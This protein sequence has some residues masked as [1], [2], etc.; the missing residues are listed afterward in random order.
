MRRQGSPQRPPSQSGPGSASATG[1]SLDALFDPRSI[2]VVGASDDPAK[3]GHILSRRALENSGDR[4]VVLVNRRGVPVL[5][6]ASH[7]TVAAAT[8]ATG[9]PLDRVVVCVPSREL[10]P[11]VAAALEAGARSLVVITAGLSELGAEGAATEDEVVRLV[12][13]AGAV[14]VGPNCLGIVDTSVDL[15]LTHDVLPV[16]SVAVLSQSGNVVLDLAALLDDRGLGVSRFVSLGNQADLSVVE[17]MSS[18]LSHE[19][20]RAVAIYAEDVV[21]GRAFVE[22]ARTLVAAGKPVVLMAPGRSAAAVR[23]A[24]S[25]T[26]SLTSASRVVDAACA[27]AGAHRVD[28]PTQ[29]ADLLQGLLADRRMAGR[30]VGIL[31]DG[32]GHGAI[33]GDALSAV[34]LDAPVLAEDTSKAL[35]RLLRPSSVV[36]NPVDLAGAG[37]HDPLTYVSAVTTLLSADEVDGVLMTGYFGGYSTQESLLGPMEVA[38]AQV[39]VDFVAGQSKPVVVH[40]IFP[41]GP[42]AA[43]LRAGGIPVHRGVDR[44]AAVLAGLVE[45][46]SRSQESLVLPPAAAPV[47]DTTYDGARGLFASAGVAFPPA[48][49]VRDPAAFESALPGLAFPVVLKALG[50]VHKSDGGGV[51]LGV[52]D[53]AAARVAYDDLL[54]RL[55]P[56]AVSVESMADTSSG[57]ELIVGCVRDPRF[58]PVLMVGLGGVFTEVLDDTA[59]A[60]APVSVAGAE[61]LLRSLRAAALLTGAR[62]RDPIDLPALATLVSRVSHLAAEHPEVQELELNPVLATP[63][64]AV[65]LDARVVLD[66]GPAGQPSTSRR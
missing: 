17:L 50:Q 38:A 60:I 51:V 18:C 57:V 59:L 14:L 6:R 65:A 33:A 4:P 24:V 26:G 8:A 43:L 49:T 46:P 31:T 63:T 28:N 34:G 39:L 36:S 61:R 62:G 56:P 5:G 16:G 54:L 44:A 64:G 1:R 10:V 9:E 32:G 53:D 21:D 47:T 2:T 20:T 35:R 13:S 37:E 30:G 29:M 11:A 27:A 48:A 25:H 45:D 19:G 15:Q 7:P 3:W 58:G 55:D 42:T 22:A 52:Q 23:S 41:A 66:P 12:R 40:T